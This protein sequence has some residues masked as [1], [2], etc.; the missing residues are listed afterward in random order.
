MDCKSTKKARRAD[1]LASQRK[2]VPLR[3]S[4]GSVDVILIQLLEIAQLNHNFFER[5]R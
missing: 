1:C 3:G 4:L 2:S 5:I